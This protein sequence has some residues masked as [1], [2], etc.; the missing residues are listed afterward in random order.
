[1]PALL[2]VTFRAGKDACAPR[3]YFQSRQGCLRSQ[4]LFSEQA[5]MPALP[6]VIFR[7]GRDA[8]APRS[9]FQSR[10]GCLRSQAIFVAGI[11]FEIFLWR[12]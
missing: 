9:Y 10:Q 7:A 5:R 3:S 4:G 6:R 12:E 1:M 2:G 8:C 11:S